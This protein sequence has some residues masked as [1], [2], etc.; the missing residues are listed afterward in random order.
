MKLVTV[1][2]INIQLQLQM[3]IQQQMVVSFS[4]MKKFVKKYE[5]HFC[6]SC[7]IHKNVA[8]VTKIY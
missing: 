4:K 8:K 1:L 7:W 6:C 2:S 3:E 5:N